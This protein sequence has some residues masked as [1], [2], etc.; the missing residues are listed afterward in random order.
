MNYQM[1][2][3]GA[4]ILYL[5]GL[6]LS[7]KLMNLTG[8]NYYIFMGLMSAIGFSAVAIFVWFWGKLRR[9]KAPAEGDSSSAGGAQEVDL[10]IRDA[11]ARLAASKLAQ[12][13]GIS[14][15]PVIFVIGQQGSVKTSTILHSGLDPELLA[16]QIYQENNVVTPTR[17][18]NVWFANNSVFAEAGAKVLA[19]GWAWARMVQRLK[20]GNLKSVV[21]GSSQA[22]RGALL[23]FDCEW[24]TRPGSGDQLASTAR[25]L[26]AR[27]GQISETLG[28]SFPVYVLFTR[29]DRVPFFA[30]YV[31]T[32]TNDEAAQVFGITL[33]IRQGQSAGVY[34]EE[35]TRRLNAAFDALFYS[36]CDRRIE[37]LPRETDADKLPGA[38]EFPREFRKVRTAL[39]QFL[40]DVCRPSQLRASPF[41]RGFYF[42]GVRPVVVNEMALPQTP[43]EPRKASYSGAAT[44]IFGVAQFGAAPQGQAAQPQVTGTKKVPQWLFL[45]HLFHYVILKDRAAMGASGSSVRTSKLQ[46]TLLALAAIFCLIFSVLFI[47]SYAKN[48]GLETNAITAAQ[49]IPSADASGNNLA[50]VESLRKL[51]SLRQSLELLTRYE[52]EGAPTMYRWGLYSGS[53][54]Y[55]EVRRIYYNRFKQLLFGQTQ[56]GVRAG[57]EK[58]PA[59]PGPNDAY[60]PTYDALKAYLITTSNHDK[61]TKPFLSPFLLARWSQNRGVEAERMQLAQKQFDFYSE[62]LRIANPYSSENDPVAVDRA[63][64]YLA[65]F[66]GIE[67]VYQFMLAEAGR[68]NPTVNYNAKFA[69]SADAVL[70]NRDVSGAFTKGGWAFMQAAI[71]KA[72]QYFGGERWV[73]G[74]YAAANIDRAKLEQDLQNRYTS[75]FIAQ[76]RDY[77]KRSVVL[78]YANLKDAA[79]KLNLQSG[80]QSPILELFWLASQNT[81]VDSPK[82]TEAFQPV[83]QVV[84]AASVD[85]FVS[86]SNQPY[87]NSLLTLQNAID[88]AANAPSGP[89]PATAQA[90]MGTA[91]NARM[92]VKQV[93]QNFRIDPEAHTEATVQRLLEEPITNAE[94][95]LRRMGPD[96]L[97]GKGKAFCAAFN[98]YPFNSNA[99]AEATMQDVSQLFKPNEGVL[100]TF[101]EQNLKTFVLRQGN[102]FVANPSGGVS[103]NP[104]F[105]AFLNTAARIS[106]AFYKGGPEPHFTYTVTPLK[107]EG[108]QNLILTID[109]ATMNAPAQGGPPKQFVLPGPGTHAASLTAT[110][111]GAPVGGRQDGL[112]GAFRLFDAADRWDPAGNGYKLEYRLVSSNRLGRLGS[113]AEAGAPA[114]FQLDL[115]GVPAF[116]RKG[117]QGM[118]CI[119]QVA[120]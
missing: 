92:T 120:K 64:K 5:I 30:E 114:Y 72:D 29:T 60:G 3:A 33:P 21:G 82:V 12:G 27:L 24:F 36:L 115:G 91:S 49:A 100:W 89:D 58:L 66:S 119:S 63:R 116:F 78:K 110:V 105:I 94:G 40:V 37:F 19:D 80:N 93:A 107:A 109:G 9:G 81:A 83:H 46:R 28:I 108:I 87:L 69:G 4:Y 95:L 39:V 65:Q 34:A 74:D 31:R 38:Y 88:Q 32:L 50:S 25:L 7:A 104:A 59:T 90:T 44:G 45:S 13:A 48:R 113:A 56:E 77:L 96:E 16:G 118:H 71:K 102:T 117:P 55:P 15:L 76:W 17:A 85:R 111:N 18:A 68:Q 35:E 67:R 1:A 99:T 6:A 26:Q 42:S 106:E 22:P 10:L 14:N 8:S 73:L 112:W 53:S 86:P 79:T 84:P 62:D 57:L 43:A 52:S 54:M 51:E 75:D 101:Y 98:L 47:V 41:L 61:S 23:C 20:P 11:D 97:N 103:I 70:N 2:A